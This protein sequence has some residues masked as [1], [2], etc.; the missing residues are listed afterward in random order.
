[1]TNILHIK[2]IILIQIMLEAYKFAE[3]DGYIWC[4]G[5]CGK[6]GKLSRNNTKHF[7]QIVVVVWDQSDVGN[8]YFGYWAGLG[9]FLLHYIFIMITFPLS[10]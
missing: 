2:Q 8:S 7:D 1:M 4:N 10:F 5:I 3:Q 6:P 9:L